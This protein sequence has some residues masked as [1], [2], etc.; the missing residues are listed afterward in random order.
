MKTCFY[1]IILAMLYFTSA[2]PL[3]AQNDQE[4]EYTQLINQ[5][6]AE[7]NCTVAQSFYDIYKELVKHTNPDIERRIAECNNGGANANVNGYVDLGL[8]S[9]KKWAAANEEGLYTFDDA[10]SKFGDKLPTKEDFEELKEHCNLTWTGEGF[11]FTSRFNGK[12][13]ILPAA[14]YRRGNEDDDD[15]REG[16]KYWSSTPADESGACNLYFGDY[17]VFMG[18]TL[19]FFSLSVRL[20]QDSHSYVDLGLPSG[21]KWATTNEDGFYS[22]DDAVSKF[23]KRLPSEEDFKELKIY[24]KWTWTGDGYKVTSR[25]N[26]KSIT[27]PAAGYGGCDG[28]MY[29]VVG[30]LG[31]YWSSSPNDWGAFC[32]SLGSGGV[33]V[34]S[35]YPCNGYSVRLIKDY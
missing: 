11:K 9:G 24:C 7:G 14:G 28:M 16:G 27:L 23:G 26:E 15:I 18:N 4:R 3:L 6:L 32:L 35:N 34:I 8:P 12:S 29:D 5:Q 2:M 13:I 17:Y 30:E 1:T 25:I 10:V 22:F 19:R 20:V 31:R 21:K 33:G